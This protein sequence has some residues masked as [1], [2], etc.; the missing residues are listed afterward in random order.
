MNVGQTEDLECGGTQDCQGHGTMGEEAEEG[1]QETR[2]RRGVVTGP[3]TWYAMCISMCIAT[4][5]PLYIHCAPQ[6]V[7][8]YEGNVEPNMERNM[9]FN[10]QSNAF[11]H[12]YLLHA[13]GAHCGGV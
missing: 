12:V 3:H 7:A 10:V 6:H 8:Q 11:L 9:T 5:T 4:Y 13:S 1:E 2:W